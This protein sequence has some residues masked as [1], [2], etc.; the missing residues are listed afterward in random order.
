M[1]PNRF[2]IHEDIRHAHTLPAAFYRDAATFEESKEHIFSSTWQWVAEAGVIAEPLQVWPFTLLPGVLDEPLLF[3]RDAQGVA[4]CVSNVCTHRGKIVIEQPGKQ[5]LL[6]CGYHGRC[7]QLD[8][9]FRSMPEFKAVENFP[10][11]A[12]NL[13][14]VSFAEWIGLLFV[15][16]H[17][18]APF[19]D[20]IQ[21]ILDRIGWMPLNTLS[22]HAE[23]SQDYEVNAHWALYCDNYLEG[24]HIPFVHPALNSAIEFGQY[25]YEL[26]PFCNL[27]LG[28]AKEGEPCFE[29]PPG[30]PDYGQRIYA[31]Y[32][33]VFP[34]LMFNF[35]PWGL[36]LNV[37]EPL[38]HNRTRIRF[39]TYY[40][41]DAASQRALNRLDD[42]EMEDE[43]VVESVQ[44]GIQSRFYHAGRYSPSQEQGVHHFHRLIQSFTERTP[45]PFARYSHSAAP[46]STPQGPI[47][48]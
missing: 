28:I 14:P 19:Q 11:P 24:F 26:Y 48:G 7:F 42:T 25:T 2:Y 37:V 3:T 27:Q 13:A 39:R 46:G 41:Q 23:H 45:S 38:S 40:F 36:S 4:H 10:T 8:G 32:Y 22:F 31:Y 5:R 44:R 18:V 33:W 9:R 34:N 35:Y 6:S 15:S 17:P 30:A 43:A 1:M 16:L 20:F 29:I 47:H 21:P 12:D